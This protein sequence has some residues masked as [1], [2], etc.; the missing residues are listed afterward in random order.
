MA[1]RLVP[2]AVAAVRAAEVRPNQRVLD[3][4]TG[5]G[6]AALLAADLG[7]QVVAVDFE[8][9]L[10]QIARARASESAVSVR[11]ENADAEALPIS[12]GWADV[13]LSVFGVMYAADHERAAHELARCV[14]S[15]GRIVLASW[16]PG[17]FMPAMGQVLGEFLPPPAPGSGPPS[18]WG[19]PSVLEALFAPTAMHV[20]AHSTQDLTMMFDNA[21]H[22]TD[23]LVRTAGNA[24]AERERLAEQGRWTDMQ[25]AVQELVEARGQQMDGQHRIDFQYLL[26]TVA[27]AE[28]S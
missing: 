23:F 2:V 18:R 20:R 5:T 10:L 28:E 7:A 1:E 3:V 15:G 17:S 24:I 19:D 12:D 13:V 22:A 27:S 4:A 14:A 21:A 16:V 8:P 6:N 11:W 25:A 26:A 9:A